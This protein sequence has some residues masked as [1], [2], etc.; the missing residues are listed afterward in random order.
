MILCKKLA[1]PLLILYDK[2]PINS[3][4][5]T[6]T[7]TLTGNWEPNMLSKVYFS[8]GNV[9]IVQ[10]AIKAGV[11]KQSNGKFVI[12]DQDEDTLKIIMR[13]IFLQRS[14][15]MQNNITQ[16]VE[17]LNKLVAD[18]CVPQI[19]GKADGYIKYKRDVSTMAIPMKD[20]SPQITQI[21]CY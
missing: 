17:G 12:G 20:L 16:Q 2:I 19:L 10:N 14:A 8:A 9:R 15:N 18:Y 4:S 3:K 1:A 5:S 11:Y 6:Y 7:D 21:H 13:S